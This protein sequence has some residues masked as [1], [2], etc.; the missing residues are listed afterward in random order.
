MSLAIHFGVREDEIKTLQDQVAR[1]NSDMPES[2]VILRTGQKWQEFFYHNSS[3]TDSQHMVIE[4]VIPMVLLNLLASRFHQ[5][6]VPVE[7][8]DG[9]TG[10]LLMVTDARDYGTEYLELRNP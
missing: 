4:T 9:Y 10:L 5:F 2:P 8:V 3:D 7:E 6:L 1:I